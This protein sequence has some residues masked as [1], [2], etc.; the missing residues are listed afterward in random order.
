MNLVRRKFSIILVFLLSIMCFN[1]FSNDLKIVQADDMTVNRGNISVSK[2][3]THNGKKA[4]SINIPED[5]RV[6]D[7]DIDNKPHND[8][9]G[10]IIG[11]EVIIYG[12]I[13]NVTYNNL[14][15]ELEDINDI[16]YKF[17]ISP[18]TTSS[19]TSSQPNTPQS[20]NNQTGNI[21]EISNYLSTL[22]TNIFEREI[23]E[24]GLNYWTQKLMN[25]EIRLK[26]LFKNLLSEIEFKQIAPTIDIKIRKIYL[27]I[28]QREPDTEGFNYWVKIFK[29]ELVSNVNEE[30]ALLN[31]IDK[32][33]NGNEFNQ[34]LSKLS[35]K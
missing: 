23:E 11:N 19:G 18:F 1:T 3:T 33:T 30:D 29:K 6:K 24:E 25:S 8:I 14:I 17:T 10:V 22:Y 26:N 34:I 9:D 28:F 12:L 32:M 31:V 35:V 20:P 5:I 15:L 13:A 2:V 16:V 21:R 7:V 27:G 4:V